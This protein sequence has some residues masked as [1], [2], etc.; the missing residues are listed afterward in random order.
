M[1]ESVDQGII[2]NPSVFRYRTR[3]FI[4]R[5]QDCSNNMGING[6]LPLIVPT[7]KVVSLKEFRKK[8]V[9]IDA[10]GWYFFLPVAKVG[11]IEVVIL[12]RGN[13][14]WGFRLQSL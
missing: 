10:S 2:Q 13:W 4:P 1:E 6:L 14:G 3:L 11:S 12:V 5:K 9:A 7:A 8:R